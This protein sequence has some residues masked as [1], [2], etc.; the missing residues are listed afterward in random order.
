MRCPFSQR[1]FSPGLL[2][3]L[4]STISGDKLGFYAGPL[5]SAGCSASNPSAVS[6]VTTTRWASWQRSRW[7]CSCAAR[8]PDAGLAVARRRRA[9][10][11]LALVAAGPVASLVALAWS[12]S[13]G[14]CWPAS[15]AWWPPS[16]RGVAGLAERG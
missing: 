13:E 3:G 6:P 4:W 5:S 7:W 9:P 2:L 11:W 14:R 15:A 10:R 1:W 12:Q 8:W 16:S